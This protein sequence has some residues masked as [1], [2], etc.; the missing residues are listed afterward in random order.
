MTPLRDTGHF[1]NARRLGLTPHTEAKTGLLGVLK[2]LQ[3]YFAAG[4]QL[5]PR[6]Y[7]A[8]VTVL[9]EEG[10]NTSVTSFT[11]LV[12]GREFPGVG[13]PFL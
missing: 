13:E 9:I 1:P 10:G 2:F 12:S 11:Q 6:D 4:P 8:T 7:N 3:C 5:T